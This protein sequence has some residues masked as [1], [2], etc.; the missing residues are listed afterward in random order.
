MAVLGN[1]K[2]TTMAQMQAVKSLASNPDSP[3]I[4]L[5]YEENQL[6]FEKELYMRN[7]PKENILKLWCVIAPLVV[8]YPSGNSIYLE[9]AD[10]KQIMADRD[11]K[12]EY[13]KN[14]SV[15]HLIETY[16]TQSTAVRECWERA[17]NV[18]DF[19]MLCKEYL[20]KNDFYVLTDG[21]ERKKHYYDLSTDGD[22]NGQEKAYRTYA[23]SSGYY[24]RNKY[25]W[26]G[27]TCARLVMLLEYYL[28]NNLPYDDCP[29]N[30]NKAVIPLSACEVPEYLF[31]NI[32]TY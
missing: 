3:N 29:E 30:Y 8:I 9:L 2:Y 18:D 17:K 26:N 16:Y 25:E 24:N 15:M 23:S 1:T 11:T 5:M 27:A 6:T 32:P 4:Y 21:K 20:R 14:R 12:A 31:N 7:Y 19:Q 10:V 28:E 13:W 22:Y